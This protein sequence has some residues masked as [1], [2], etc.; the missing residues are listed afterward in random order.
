[1]RERKKER[2]RERRERE[3][4]KKERKERKLIVR[5]ERNVKDIFN[6]ILGKEFLGFIPILFLEKTS[7][8]AVLEVETETI[9]KQFD[10]F[11]HG[12]VTF[13]NDFLEHLNTVL[14]DKE[15]TE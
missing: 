8:D 9:A 4:K 5:E 1:M 2:E 15:T 11:L 14:L 7:V 13:L 6:T 3:L 12:Q 10:N